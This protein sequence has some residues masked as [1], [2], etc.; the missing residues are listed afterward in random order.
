MSILSP[1][2]AAYSRGARQRLFATMI[3]KQPVR[4]PMSASSTVLVV[5]SSRGIGSEFV[6]QCLEKGANVHATYRGDVLPTEIEELVRCDRFRPGQLTAVQM[7]VT[8]EVSVARAA[9]SCRA[10]AGEGFT[11]IIHN[12]GIYGTQ[13]SIDGK[14]WGSRSAAAPISKDVM[15][16]VFEANAVGP[17]LVAQ[18]F[19]PLLKAPP[20]QPVYAFLTSK[21]GSIQDNGS[22]G[23]Y[24]YRASKSALNMIAKSLSVDL[25]GL[26]N[27][28]L[29]HAG[30]VRTDM[31]GGN[32]LIGTSESAA[33]M[34]RAI[35]ATDSSSDFRWVDYKAEVVPW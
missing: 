13:V 1:I 3:E 6:R 17:L 9:E 12:A 28:V 29:L 34:L 14:A 11:H 35:E 7:D 26:A 22:G 25:A 31:T 24:A 5:G 4:N 18:A 19:Y 8:D 10:T 21:V 27:V 30:Y 2:A 33:G 16:E 23:A 15:M 32:G 20:A